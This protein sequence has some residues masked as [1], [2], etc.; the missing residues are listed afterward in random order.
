MI[1]TKRFHFDSAHSLPNYHGKCA[2]L[3]GHRWVLD[4]WVEGPVNEETGMVMDFSE[5]EERVSPVIRRFDHHYL[6]EQM[7]N[8]TCENIL[9][10]IANFLTTV[11]GLNWVRLRLKES[12]DSWA[13]IDRKEYEKLING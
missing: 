12:P 9:L 3:H 6:N 2:N 10:E 8:P 13:T 5:L 1:V 11:D 4:V 7:K